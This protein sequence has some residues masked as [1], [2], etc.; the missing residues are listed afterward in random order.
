MFTTIADFAV[1]WEREAELTERVLS[2]LT[3]ESLQQPIDS[4]RRTLGKLAWHL[5]TSASFMTSL[6]LEF[7]GVP[8]GAKALETADE[9]AKEYR[10]INAALL[11]AVKTQWG[12]G[13]L[14]ETISIMGEEW[15]N[16]DSL[17]FS[18]MHQAHHRGQMTVLMRQAGLRPPE[19]YGPTY[20]AWVDKGMTPLA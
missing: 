13:S 15:R 19:I 2:A 12:D 11:Q 18:I 3:D 5:V 20:E 6:G 16:G 7:E 14:N 1:E 10:R 9:I 4:E 8:Q 17:R